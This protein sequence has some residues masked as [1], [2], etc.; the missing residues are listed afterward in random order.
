MRNV[1]ACAACHGPE[2]LKT[3]ASPLVG[4]PT[5]YLSNQLVAFSQGTRTND[6]NRQMRL[7]ASR[8]TPQEVLQLTEFFGSE[9]SKTAGQ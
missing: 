1:V 6:I 9:P 8:L 7:I 2:G 5:E 4:Q 3:G